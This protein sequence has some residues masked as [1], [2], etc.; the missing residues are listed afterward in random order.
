MNSINEYFDQIFCINMARSP[1]RLDNAHQQAT[2]A[3]FIFQRFEAYDYADYKGLPDNLRSGMENPMCG[4]TASHG[5]LLA[6]IAANGWGRTLILEDDFEVL[7][8][9]FT[10]RFDVLHKRVPADWDLLYLGAGY[11]EEPKSRVNE[12]V[13]RA[14]YMKTTSSY[15]VTGKYARTLAP[16]MHGCSGP[17]DLLS[18]FNPHFKCYVLNPRLMGQIKSVSTIWGTE[19]HNTQSM[20]D[21][22]HDRIINSLQDS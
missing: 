8:S 10:A 12:S 2:K 15:A 1:E 11:G 17:D 14:G 6:V 21:P 9:D 7:H 3:G 4:C 5:A 18:G 22:P 16:F 20:T 19:T 13:V